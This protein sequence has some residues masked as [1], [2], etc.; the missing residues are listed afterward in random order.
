VTGTVHENS[1][2]VQFPIGHDN[3]HSGSEVVAKTYSE[4]T[5][6]FAFTYPVD[7]NDEYVPVFLLQET[8]PEILGSQNSDS[9]NSQPVFSFP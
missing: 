7:D 3:Q 6:L 2:S 8:N 9:S 1:F 5:A 4:L